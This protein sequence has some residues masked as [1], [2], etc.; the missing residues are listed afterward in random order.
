MDRP[1][2]SRPSPGAVWTATALRHRN[3]PL[4]IHSRDGL[5]GNQAVE[6]GKRVDVFDVGHHGTG[7]R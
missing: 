5:S 1:R 4:L 6:W 2:L 7:Y 3:S